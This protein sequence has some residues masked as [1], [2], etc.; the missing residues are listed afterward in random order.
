MDGVDTAA[1]DPAVFD[2]NLAALRECDLAQA[3]LIASLP[4]PQTVRPCRGRDG[5]TT[6]RIV[7]DDGREHWFGGTSAPTVSAPALLSTF[8]T[9]A[10]NVLL[11]GIGQGAEA[12]WLVQRLEAHRGV[13]VLETVP[14]WL[15]LAMR[16]HD[17]AEALRSRRLVFIGA[18]EATAENRLAEFFAGHPGYCFPERLLIWPWLAS[19]LVEPIRLMVERSAI[20]V[21][22][23]RASALAA[24]QASWPKTAT[25]SSPASPRVAVV[26]RMAT[27]TARQWVQDAAAAGRQLGWTTKAF[28]VHGPDDCHILRLAKELQAFSPE[29]VLAIRC[30]RDALGP[31][32]APAVPIVSWLDEAGGTIPS[33]TPLGPSDLL[34]VTSA[35]ARERILPEAISRKQVEVVPPAAP[36][37]AAG[38]PPDD[39]R[40]YDVVL[41]SDL[42]PADP[43]EAGI[44]LHTQQVLWGESA[45]LIRLELDSFTSERAGAILS[46]AEA[47]T[48]MAIRDPTVRR[49]FE[50]VIAEMVGPSVVAV[51]LVGLLA[52]A[53]IAVHVWGAGWEKYRITG[54]HHHGG[55][56][57]PPNS[58]VIFFKT[59]CYVS[60][61][62]GGDV[63]RDLFDAAD[64]GAVVLRRAH[65]ADRKEG[66]IGTLFADGREYVAFRTAAELVGTV[67]T[68]LGDERRRE[69]LRRAAAERLARDHT[70]DA[71]LRTIQ[72]LL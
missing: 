56:E 44:N 47:R 23:Q 65:P 49:M 38:R 27:P 13:L 57:P 37:P 48:G 58:R 31:A 35:A 64:A 16:L 11:F 62:T 5:T 50:Q 61:G 71:R 28:T 41:M 51:N 34:V 15:A 18:E 7:G 68:L 54:M 39:D 40:P 52:A 8:D 25:S 3:D 24:I 67:R 70:M 59:K 33:A 30:T 17:Y 43:A 32:V 53:G 1:I 6:F 19:S 20:A 66:G 29:W 45:K 2:R 21:Q 10:G 36:C 63:G 55:L 22:R 26:A 14:L 9:G 72:A 46:A 60:C 42:T 4:L 12:A 69:A